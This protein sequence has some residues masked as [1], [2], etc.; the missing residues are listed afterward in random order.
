MRVLIVGDIHIDSNLEQDTDELLQ[1]IIGYSYEH[2][3]HKV[4]LLGDIYHR[5]D[6]QKGSKEEMRFHRF[7]NSFPETTNIHILTGNHDLSDDRN[8]LSEVKFNHKVFLYDTISTPFYI[9][10][11][12]AVMLPWELHRRAD[13]VEWFKEKC[14]YLK[15]LNEE[16]ILFAHI[17]FIEAKFNNKK[18]ISNQAKNFPS[19]QLLEEIPNFS[20]AFLGD[21]HLP[22]D[23]GNKA[24]YVGSIRNS[25]FAESG[26]KR[27][28]LLDSD[29]GAGVNLWLGCRDTYSADVKLSDLQTVLSY[30]FI[31]NK[32]VKLKVSCTQEEYE[33]GIG[34]LIHSAHLLKIDYEI[35]G[36]K[37]FKSLDIT[38]DEKMFD[39]YC[40][41]LS[42]KYGN[43]TINNVKITG[44][45]IIHG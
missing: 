13:S 42:G 36:K 41:T 27:V 28:I 26:D 21:I 14:E 40:N 30:P 29:T 32:I 20:F 7:L 44:A 9:G 5:R 3:C 16:F 19:I 35:Q 2:E 37:E 34:E 10:D 38:D 11:K 25:N 18:M 31:T 8:L 6:V 17:P 15:T 39:I 24:L 45:D 12:L 4:I 1:K 33:K 23:I 43:D 22:Q